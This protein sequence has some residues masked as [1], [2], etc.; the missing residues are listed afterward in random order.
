MRL[1]NTQ[2]LMRS[3]SMNK[4]AKYSNMADE[5]V[6]FIHRIQHSRFKSP[7]LVFA[8]KTNLI[9]PCNIIN[10]NNNNNNSNNDV[11]LPIIHYR[12]NIAFKTTVPIGATK[13]AKR[14]LIN[15]AN[16]NGDKIQPKDKKTNP[17]N[18]NDFR[19]GKKERTTQLKHHL[20]DQNGNNGN[21]LK[22][23]PS[24]EIYPNV[25]VCNH[26][27][28][29]KYQVF[30]ESNLN[31]LSIYKD[32]HD[33]E[34]DEEDDDGLEYDDDLAPQKKIVRKSM[35]LSQAGI[36]NDV[37]KENQDS[38]LI[39]NNVIG[40]DD[41][42]IYGVMDGHGANGHLVSGYIK[43]A[44]EEYFNK[45]ETYF[46]STKKPRLPLTGANILHKLLLHD[47]ALIKNFYHKMNNELINEKFDVHYSGS[48]CVIVF[49]VNNKLICANAG[50]SR[51][52]MIKDSFGYKEKKGSDPFA[53]FETDNLSRDH[54]PESPEEKDRIEKMGGVVDQSKNKEGIKEGPF[55]VWVKGERHP[56]LAMSRSIGD[57]IAESIGAVH[58]PEIIVKDITDSTKYIVL[59]SDGVW[60][61]LNNDQVMNIINNFFFKND[62]KGACEAAVSEA[63]SLWKKEDEGRDDITIV[64]SFLG[65]IHLK[66]CTV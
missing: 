53:F 38:F 7:N 46:P 62:I 20:N 35:G 65:H 4:R 43:Q 1:T 55:R 50:D 42:H 34:N 49:Q 29:A 56:G 60:E 17:M 30:E 48:T 6:F 21:I 51:A 25:K 64:I 45:E 11:V 3:F 54:K 32:R 33:T 12:T 41:Y 59:A 13:E 2:K 14:F 61:F 22:Q 47:Y 28:V 9:D 63:T 24:G 52:I 66:K 27:V 19:I 31:T 40:I 15:K 58:D 39:L 23:M 5:N 18:N 10:E 37:E 8:N 26:P 16:S 44:A 57:E 36:K